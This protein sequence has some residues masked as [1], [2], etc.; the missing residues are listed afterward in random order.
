M[1][2]RDTTSLVDLHNHLV[3]GVDD[4]ARNLPAAL[5]SVQRMTRIGIRRIVT[6]PHI[7]GSLTLDRP[8]LHARL[9][10][11]GAAFERTRAAI[12]G[13][14][15]EVEFHRGHEVLIDVPEVDLSDVRLRMAGTSF[16]LVE[17]PRLQVPP[18]TARVLARLR[19]QGFRPVVAHP[20]RYLGML[21][22][23][24]LAG[25]WR[26]IGAYLQVN[27]GSLVGRYGGE[28]KALAFRLLRQGWV[29]YLASDFHGQPSL[30]IHHKEAWAELASRDALDIATLLCR[31]N[32]A[33]L[34]ED[35]EPLPVGALPHEPG[36]LR[37]LRGI[38]KRENV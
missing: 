15:P 5:E 17:W 38:I 14:F 34:L 10:E 1:S 21:Q 27:Y 37:R 4:G 35:R 30:K 19:E 20:E 8:R 7:Q 26:E 36:F 31:T 22:S 24:G 33:R 13:E 28:A 11:V 9:E 2:V 6:T 18:G 29:D 12:A 16:V 23:F 32:P 3:P 25:Q